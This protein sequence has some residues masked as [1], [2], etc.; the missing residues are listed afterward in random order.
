VL[1]TIIQNCP[2]LQYLDIVFKYELD[3]PNFG[4][5]QLRE[6]KMLRSLAICARVPMD[7]AELVGLVKEM[8]NLEVPMGIGIF[9]DHIY[10]H[11]EPGHSHKG[12]SENHV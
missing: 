5:A 10:S 8:P 6:L 9:V 4:I 3:S 12:H 1:S 2:Q 7:A 11:A